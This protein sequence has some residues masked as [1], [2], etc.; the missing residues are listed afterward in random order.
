MIVSQRG[1]AAGDAAANVRCV[2]ETG[3]LFATWA[4]RLECKAAV[5]RPDRYVFGVANN[6]AQLNRLVGAVGEH[7]LGTHGVPV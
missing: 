5:V 7:V 4:S 3:A 1:Q 6:A 2:T